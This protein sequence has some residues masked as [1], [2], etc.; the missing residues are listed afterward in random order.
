MVGAALLAGC[1]DGDTT[2]VVNQTT[3]TVATEGPPQGSTSTTSGSSTTT[4]TEGDGPVLNLEAF[5]SPSGNIACVMTQR[6]VRCDIAERNWNP[7]PAPAACQGDYGQGIQL[8]ASGPADFVCAGD[9]VLNPQ[10]ETLPYGSSSQS[11]SITCESEEAGIEC[12]NESGGG[13]TLSREQYDLN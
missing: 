4:T 10:A 12:E 9:T 11:G 1:G 7:P 6:S 8:P 13:F 3:T 2:T 5:Q